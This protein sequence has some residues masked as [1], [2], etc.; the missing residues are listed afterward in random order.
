MSQLTRENPIK[1]DFDFNQSSINSITK[2]FTDILE[3][4]SKAIGKTNNNTKRNL[5]P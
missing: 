2:N 3:A 1:I 4:A 5:V